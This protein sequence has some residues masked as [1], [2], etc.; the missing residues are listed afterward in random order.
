MIFAVPWALLGLVALPAVAG[1]YLLH[2]RSRPRSVSSLMLWTD[3]ALPRQGGRT[4]Q[5]MQLPLLLLLEL[6][7]LAMLVLAAVNPHMQL[8]A[9]RQAVVVVL[10][11][12]FSMTAG[13]ES[14]RT[15]ALAELRSLKITG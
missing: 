14:P 15:L 4:L 11:D 1:I 6:F 5:R 9:T 10:D 7:I 2:N 8:G 12:S 3:Q 13:P